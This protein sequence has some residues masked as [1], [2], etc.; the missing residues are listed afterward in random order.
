[1]SATKCEK[2]VG[3]AF[4]D[5]NRG[6]S[7]TQSLCNR[8]GLS[9]TRLA[10][11]ASRRTPSQAT[12]VDMLGAACAATFILVLGI[13]AYWD[14]SIRVLHVF[15]AFP[16][17]LAAVLCVRRRKLGY[18]LGCASG[19]FWLWMAGTQ[20]SFVRNG[21]ERLS[22]LI[23]T[24]HVDRWDQFIAAPAALATGGLAVFSVWGYW[25]LPTRRLVDLVYLA[26]T[27][28]MIGLF[29]ATIFWLFAPR[30][31]ALFRGLIS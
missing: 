1:M 5:T 24:G 26:S 30:Y 6:E 2:W 25:R 28:A 16:Y 19:G 31:L 8:I 15:E 14:A 10:E 11:G 20:T 27:L 9:M 18:M 21:F 12:I 23:M 4:Y 3:D 22:M 7:L 13:S 29:F 17:G